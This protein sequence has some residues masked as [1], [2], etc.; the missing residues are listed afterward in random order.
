[1][2]DEI[3]RAPDIFQSLHGIIDDDRKRNTGNGRFLILGSASLDLLKQTSETLAGRIG[4]VELA[5][6]LFLKF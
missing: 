3:Q 1:V 4:F 5:H 6:F 2:L